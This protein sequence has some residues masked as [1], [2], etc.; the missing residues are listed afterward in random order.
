MT[1]QEELDVFEDD[2]I[3]IKS[4]FSALGFMTLSSIAS[5]KTKKN[6]GGLESEYIKMRSNTNAFG[7]VCTKF[8]AL[9]QIESFTSGIKATM[10]DV[11][12]HLNQKSTPQND[13]DEATRKEM[14]ESAQKV[15]REQA[16]K[17][18]IY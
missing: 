3:Q 16:K 6:L 5:I 14:L 1:L 11:I 17:V 7:A 9:E 8:P 18:R 13:V 4:I 10:A 15:V 2:L 12:K